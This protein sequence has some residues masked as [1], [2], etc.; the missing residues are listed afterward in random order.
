MI[1]DIFY[2]VYLL[3]RDVQWQKMQKMFSTPTTVLIILNLSPKEC[4][5]VLI[6]GYRPGDKTTTLKWKKKKK[7]TVRSSM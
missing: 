7:A 4:A 5:A 1:L 3:L 6:K 2:L